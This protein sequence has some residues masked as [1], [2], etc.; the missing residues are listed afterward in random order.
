MVNLTSE[1]A[2]YSLP[3]EVDVPWELLLTNQEERVFERVGKLD[4]YEAKLFVNSKK[5]N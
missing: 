1:V 3:N 2:E 5:R 4:P